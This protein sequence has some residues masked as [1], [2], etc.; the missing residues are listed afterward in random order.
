MRDKW[1]ISIFLVVFLYPSLAFADVTKGY[2]VGEGYSE[3]EI[4]CL[5]NALRINPHNFGSYYGLGVAYYMNGDYG[6]H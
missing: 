3:E 2:L 5:E 1:I 6:R 4:E